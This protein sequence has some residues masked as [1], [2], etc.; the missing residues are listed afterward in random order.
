[1]QMMPTKEETS[2][3]EETD[4]TLCPRLE[5]TFTFLGKKWNGLIIDVLLEDGPQRFR[6]LAHKVSR[7]SD[8]VLVERLKELEQNGVIVRRTYPDK[9]L[10]EYDL[11]TK[12]R[13]FRN[14]MTA[15]HAWSD[16]W[17]CPVEAAEK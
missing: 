12:G 4:F 15:I 3:S 5:Q 17:S 10:I 1:M 14:V 16:K 6:D 11:T 2:K 13:E 8:R 7:C 9:A